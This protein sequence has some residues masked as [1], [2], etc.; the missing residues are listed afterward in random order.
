MDEVGVGVGIL[1]MGFIVVMVA[2]FVLI[3]ASFWVVFT[4]AGQPGWASI[5]PIYNIIV[6]L[7]IAGKPTWW[8]LL[9]LL[10]LVNIVIG[11]MMAI[12]KN[13]GKSDGFG[14]GLLLLPMIFYPML[15]WGDARYNRVA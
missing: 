5:V 7:Q 4:K 2:L 14:I 15:A 10:P 8:I 13:F 9:M 12:A 11:I 1:F 3:I 6:L